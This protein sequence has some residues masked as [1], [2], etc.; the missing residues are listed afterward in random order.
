M[1]DQHNSGSV[2]RVVLVFLSALVIV[3]AGC[4]GGG[5]SQP[6]ADSGIGDDVVLNVST[7]GWETDFSRH[8][9]PLNEFESGGVP[10]DGIPAIDEPDFTTVEAASA[11]IESREPVIE[12]EVDGDVRAYPIQ[13]LIWHEIVND[14]VGGVPVAVTFCPLCNTALVFDRRVDGRVL[15]FGTTG[16]LRNADLVMYDRQ[17]ESWWQQFGG[18]A[19]VGELAGTELEPLPAR[20]VAWEDFAA[21]HPDGKVLDRPRDRDRPY[22]ENPYTGYD[23]VASPPFFPTANSGDR[24]LQPKE[25]VV[26]VEREGEAVVVPFAALAKRGRIEVEVGGEQLVVTWQKGVASALDEGELAKGREVGAAEVRDRRRRLVP[27]DTPFWFAVAAFS[28]EARIV[29]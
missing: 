17:T 27:F 25:R 22:G 10:K 8:T 2:N 18:D 12:L 24:R 23:D 29:D 14:E 11:W 20:I 21:A 6:A 4:G 13:I 15:D 7:E 3:V 28:P 26:F 16:N 1:S 19:L 9:V 5:S